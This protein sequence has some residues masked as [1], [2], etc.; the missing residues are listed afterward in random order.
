M[1]KRLPPSPPRRRPESKCLILLVGAPR[2]ELGTPSPPDWCANRAAL[3][4][5]NS[6]EAVHLRPRGRPRK[7][8]ARNHHQTPER[9]QDQK[10]VAPVV[11]VDDGAL[12]GDAQE[13]GVD[14]VV[15]RLPGRAHKHETQPPDGGDKREAEIGEAAQPATGHE[16][17]EEGVVR[18]LAEIA[19]GELQRPDA[20]RPVEHQ[21]EAK[22]VAPEAPEMAEVVVLVEGGA[23]LEKISKLAD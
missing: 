16:G 13:G 23:L 3:R 21:I 2:F 1:K 18:V 11:D 12:A 5:A 10:V 8:R 20:E 6:L 17:I 4:S 19:L 15:G 9:P 22:N 14:H 7:G